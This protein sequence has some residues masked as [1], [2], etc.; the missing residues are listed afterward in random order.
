MLGVET[1][2]TDPKGLIKVNFLNKAKTIHSVS[3]HS[4]CFAN[5]TG[6]RGNECESG[7]PEEPGPRDGRVVAV[8]Y[9]RL[10]PQD[11]IE[12]ATGFSDSNLRLDWMAQNA[13][14]QKVSNCVACASARP[15]LFTEP[16]PLHPEDKWGYDC[17]L[18]MT[19]EAVSTGNGPV[20]CCPVCSHRLT[21]IPKRDLLCPEK[22]TTRVLNFPQIK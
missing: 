19:R 10:K 9:T 13:R 2:G 4:H 3:N 12:R 8:D 7:M 20:L 1:T 21:N 11:L 17:M 18:R 6:Q 16:A 5:L 22:I 14:E 15:R